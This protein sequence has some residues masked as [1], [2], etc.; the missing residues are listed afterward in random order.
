MSLDHVELHSLRGDLLRRPLDAEAQAAARSLADEG[1]AEADVDGVR[2]RALMHL[3]ELGLAW[4]TARSS[5]RATFVPT[6]LLSALHES[7]RMG[8]LA[9]HR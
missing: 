9:P 4:V 3:C 8:E 2:G 6:R 7:N 5:N 1:V